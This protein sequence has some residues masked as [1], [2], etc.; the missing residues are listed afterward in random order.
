MVDRVK[1]AVVER[2]FK[3]QVVRGDAPVELPTIVARADMQ[4]SR[5]A[6]P[7]DAL[8][9]APPVSAARSAPAPRSASGEKVG[10]NDPCHCGSG[11]KYK[12]C[13]YLKG[14]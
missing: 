4:E 2:L 6:L 10:R 11:K 14:A 7:T 3:V 12:K 1:S 13:C 5:G 8:S 9:T